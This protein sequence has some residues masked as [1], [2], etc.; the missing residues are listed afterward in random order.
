MTSKL[1]NHL[2]HFLR[3]LSISSASVDW[4]IAPVKAQRDLL[5]KH[6]LTV[7]DISLFEINEAFRSE[8]FGLGILFFD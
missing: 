2:Y 3:P 4:P 1:Y 7:D 6:N 8:L 5:A